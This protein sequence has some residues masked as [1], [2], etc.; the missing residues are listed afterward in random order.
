MFILARAISID[1]TEKIEQFSDNLFFDVYGN[2]T[3]IR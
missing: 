3:G 2:W 1:W